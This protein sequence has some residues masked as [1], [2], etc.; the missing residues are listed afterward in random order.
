LVANEA[1]GRPNK[2]SQKASAGG[3]ASLQR[4]SPLQVLNP[5]LAGYF[6]I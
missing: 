1:E 6:Y 3:L 2:P 5:V 4:H